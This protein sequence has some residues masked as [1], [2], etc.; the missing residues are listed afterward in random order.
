M[1]EKKE[2]K[3]IC[4]DLLVLIS[5]T[6]GTFSDLR[7]LCGIPNFLQFRHNCLK[8]QNLGDTYRF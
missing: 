4:Y 2:K 6:F 1:R 7:Q 5:V 8:I 3:D